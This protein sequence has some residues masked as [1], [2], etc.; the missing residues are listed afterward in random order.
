MS[1]TQTLFLILG[2][3][4][5]L[6]WGSRMMRTGIIRAA[7]DRLPVFLGRWAQNRFQS[8][9]AGLFAGVVLQSATATTLLVTSFLAQGTMVAGVA[10]ALVLGADLGSA[11]AVFLFSLGVQAFWPLPLFTGCVL[12][13]AFDGRNNVLKSAGRLL[14]G[15]GLVLLG[16]KVLGEGARALTDSPLMSELIRAASSEILIAVLVGLFMT[17]LA[18]SSLTMVLFVA[19]LATSGN[20]PVEQLLYV[21]IGI[22][23]GAALPA[24]SATFGETASVRR[25]PLG[26]MMCRGLAAFAALL[27]V[28]PVHAWLSQFSQDPVQQIILFHLL[29]NAV[30]V[31]LLFGGTSVIS[32]LCAVMLPEGDEED[33]VRV[34]P[35]FLD[36]GLRQTPAAAIG[37]A[38]RETLRMGDVVRGMLTDA[39][40]SLNGQSS[41][42]SSHIA[43]DDDIVDE[44][45][46]SVKR[47]L[48]SLM[49]QEI[50]EEL[51]L[52]AVDIINYATNLE[53][54]GDIIDN[55][56]LEMAEKKQRA[57]LLFSAEGQKDLDQIF[58]MVESTFELSLNTFMTGH[59]DSA[60]ELIVRKTEFRNLE[61]FGTERHLDRLSDGV[62]HSLNTSSIHLDI[63]RDL[64]RINSHLISVAYPVLE[65]AGELRSSRLTK[66]AE[67]RVRFSAE[68]SPSS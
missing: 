23:I 43:E 40:L 56:L 41:A 19:T 17:W 15:L 52:R 44:L 27:S 58:E 2:G 39:R 68:T 37:A 59:I 64:K 46:D 34:Q 26:N 16:L 60:R 28:A 50:G 7:G 1:G 25:L 61:R 51:S 10:L 3:I 62:Q 33:A 6:L 22:N 11:V 24:F 13:A 54:V 20:I 31:V 5:L 66:K 12:H 8:Y 21:L 32:G 67:R 63:I 57:K 30:L 49:A 53:H 65:R 35:Q 4:G 55:N 47:Y 48:A 38:A 42:L 36:S 29:F 14:I 9:L 45:N 18:H